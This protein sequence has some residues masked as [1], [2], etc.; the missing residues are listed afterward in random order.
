[1]RNDDLWYL[2][3]IFAWLG[4]I[5]LAMPGCSDRRS[6]TDPNAFSAKTFWADKERWSGGD[7]GGP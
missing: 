7:G 1:M 2:I 6:P 3:G 5:A 4:I